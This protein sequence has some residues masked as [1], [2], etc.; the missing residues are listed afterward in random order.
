VLAT[1]Q[2]A[3]EA[4]D[5]VIAAARELKRSL[6]KHLFTY[7]PIPIS[8]ASRVPVKET[9]IGPVPENWEIVPLG[10]LATLQRGK[11]L[12]VQDR[13][14]GRYPVVGSNG[15]VGYHKEFVAEGPGVTVGRSGSVDD[16]QDS[17]EGFIMPLEA[18][19]PLAAVATK[20]A[21]QEVLEEIIRRAVDSAQAERIILFGSAA[22]G[23]MGP[24]WWVQPSRTTD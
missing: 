3:I 7:G 10:E 4:Q 13:Q 8:E 9:D 11:A 16:R 20:S 19:W 24:K 23:E 22:R 18:R 6:M 21:N 1:I 12:P 2:R 15:F 5:K 14:R 17:G